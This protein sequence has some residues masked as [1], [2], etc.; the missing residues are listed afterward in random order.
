[1]N[2][3]PTARLPAFLTGLCLLAGWVGAGLPA[4][5]ADKPGAELPLR[6]MVDPRVE[7][8]SVIFRLAGHPEYNQPRVDVYT[9]DVE[10]HF[11]KYRDHRAVTMARKLRRTRGVSY[12]ACMSMAVHLTDAYTLGEKIPLSPH[13]APLDRRW[14]TPEARDF[15]EATRQF[16]KDTSFKEFVEEHQ[17]LYRTTTSR[18]QAVLEKDGHLEWFEEFFGSRPQA[19]FT[20]TLGLLNGGQCYGALF[21]DGDSKEELFC[22]LGVWKTDAQGM[23]QFDRSMLG[24]VIH[25]FCHSYTN[26]IVHRHETE[27]KAAGEKIYPHVAAAMKRQAYGNWK[28]MMYESLVRA[29]VL[30]YTLKYDGKMAARL[31]IIEEQQRQF[32]W[33]GELSSLLGEYEKDR[34]KYPTLEAFA[35]RIVT[36]FNE[37]AE[38]FAEQQ[39]TQAARTPKAISIVPANGATDVEPG[40]STI[41]VVFDRPMKDGSWSMV[42]GGPN[43]PEISERPAYDST[44]KVWTVSVTLKP[45]WNYTFMLNS[46]TFRNFQ[47]RD[48]VPLAPV[49][50]SF[51]TGSGK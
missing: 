14:R 26:S 12:D 1:M 6:V 28:T 22:V 50:V 9:K 37:Y 41:T 36:F 16:V 2:A 4:Q 27:L 25:E 43:F 7:L 33:I 19:S 8:M 42:G 38:P 35:P 39:P 48:G 10:Q 40:P 18:M 31:K 44:G 13:P 5:A 29:C 17:D 49:V 15:L 34:T 47:S 3:R 51:R 30:R 45:N 23:P 20:V 32:L 46:G 24:T 11:G 21:K